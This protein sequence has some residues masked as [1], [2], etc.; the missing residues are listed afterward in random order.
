MASSNHENHID[1]SFE[2]PDIVTPTA[3]ELQ[4]MYDYVEAIKRTEK[5]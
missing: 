2:E 4:E 1:H 3:A 5:P